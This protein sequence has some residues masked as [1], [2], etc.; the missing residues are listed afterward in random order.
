MLLLVLGGWF[1]RLRLKSYAKRF[2]KWSLGSSA[3]WGLA[4]TFWNE[5]AVL[6]FVF[7]VLD[8]VYEKSNN[9]PSPSAKL[10]LVSFVL[11]GVFFFA[12]VYS[13]KKKRHLGKMEEV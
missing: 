4:E 1:W 3:F 10:I 9:G 7:P 13:E 8:S 11:A 5:A 12:A 6:W 2:Y